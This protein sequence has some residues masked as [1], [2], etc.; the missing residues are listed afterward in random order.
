[1]AG[2]DL[3]LPLEA[4]PTGR[5]LKWGCATLI[6]LGVLAL[7]LAA[8]ADARLDAFN[9]KPWIVTVALPPN[10]DPSAGRV[11][12]D[13][14][15]DLLRTLPGVAYASLI[16]DD[17]IGSLVKPL[18]DREMAMDAEAGSVAPLDILLPRLIDI[19]FNPGAS[20]DLKQLDN[21]LDA[22][23]PGSTVGDA[24]LLQRSQQQLARTTRAVGVVVGSALFAAVIAMAVWITRVNL[25]QQAQTIDLLRLM[26]AN[27]KYIAQQF[28]QHTLSHALLGS[29][30]GFAAAIA[31]TVIVLF[32]PSLLGQ[33]PPPEDRLAAVHWVL[34]AIVPVA[35]ALLSALTAR[36][37]ALFRLAT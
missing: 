8:V 27:D 28:E 33:G 15:L 35:A 29:L 10:E 9:R 23:V 4:M 7:A 36:L 6:Y 11:E 31:T 5:F 25:I 32:G 21:E 20:V 12:V 37:T 17:E 34:L 24:G 1:M 18:I 22:I 19:A 16:A 14:V 3:D 26:G 30:M 13:T 2:S